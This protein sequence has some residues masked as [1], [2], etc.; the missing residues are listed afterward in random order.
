MK[1]VFFIFLVLCSGVF[2]GGSHSPRQELQRQYL[3]VSRTPSDINEHMPVL[4]A[5]AKDCS[6]AVEI[7]VRNVVSTWAILWGLANSS[8]SQRA[9]L[10]IDLVSPPKNNLYLARQLA[11]K[12]QVA[13]EF[14][15]AN[16]MDIEIPR[17]DLLFIDSLHTYCHLMSELER[18]SPNVHKYIALHDTSEPW[19]NTDDWEYKGDYSE[20]P[21]H[22]DRTKR[23]LWA[24]V[25]DFLQNHPEWMLKERRLN[26]HGFTVL[27]RR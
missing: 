20:Y 14:L 22:F 2:Y 27:Q 24:A 21:A 16:D 11:G 6:S 26:N 19:G 13:F 3:D 15:V 23:G 9:Y 12:N 17:T 25:V 18:F 10:G 5:L 7:G 1:N 4:S 8:S